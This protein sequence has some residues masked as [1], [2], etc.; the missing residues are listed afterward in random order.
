MIIDATLKLEKNHKVWKW[1]NTQENKLITAGHVGTH[2]DVY[3]KTIVPLEYFK[4]KGILID[5]SKYGVDDEIGI[6]ILNGLEI[7]ENSFVMFRTNI[8]AKYEYGSDFYVK[9]HNQLEWDL[10][11]YLIGKKVAFIGIDAAGIRRD[12]EH[13]IADVKAEK[14]GVYIVENLDLSEV[15]AASNEM[16]DTFTMWIEKPNSTGLSTRVI[17]DENGEL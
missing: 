13:F 10:I 6:E 4:T 7:K 2:I 11:D 8:Q 9:N 3:K 1:L 5:C 16:F 14:N 15:K 17:I 12:K